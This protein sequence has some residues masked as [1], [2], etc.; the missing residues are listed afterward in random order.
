MPIEQQFSARAPRHP[1]QNNPELA[2]TIRGTFNDLRRR[3]IIFGAGCG[4]ATAFSAI[5]VRDFE[6]AL[7]FH[8]SERWRSI[9]PRDDAALPD[10]SP[11]DGIEAL[12]DWALAVENAGAAEA[13]RAIL[14]EMERSIAS[15]AQQCARHGFKAEDV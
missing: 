5:S 15:F 2:S 7:V 4:C 6:E 14:N 11:A 12:L 13:C 9:R 10:P 3:P 8:V 1:D